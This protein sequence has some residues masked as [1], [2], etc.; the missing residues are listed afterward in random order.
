MSQVQQLKT[1]D[2]AKNEC[3]VAYDAQQ[4][5]RIIKWSVDHDPA[6]C[7]VCQTN[8]RWGTVDT[9]LDRGYT[10]TRIKNMI[11]RGSLL[12]HKPAQ[13]VQ[14]LIGPNPAALDC[15]RLIVNGVLKVQMTIADEGGSSDGD[16]P[17]VPLQYEE[18]RVADDGAERSK[19]KQHSDDIPGDQYDNSGNFSE[20]GM[21]CKA[22]EVKS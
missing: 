2:C 10:L 1:E 11:K 19:N 18:V 15:L 22:C 16:K 3:V 4:R 8:S 9:L 21:D 12:V 5:Y 20:S 13:K 17:S 14:S 6:T 7:S